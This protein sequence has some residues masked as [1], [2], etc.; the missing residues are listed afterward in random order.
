MLPSSDFTRFLAEP[1]EREVRE[2]LAASNPADPGLY[3][4][5]PGRDSD[6]WVRQ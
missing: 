4:P 2:L 5:L 6:D 1:D 3:V